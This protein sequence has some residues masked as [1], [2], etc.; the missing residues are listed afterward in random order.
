MQQA[1]RQQYFDEFFCGR[2][3]RPGETF[4]DSG[5][6]PSLTAKNILE[7]LEV[8]TSL[9]VKIPEF[10]ANLLF[11]WCLYGLVFYLETIGVS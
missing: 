9:F 10:K 6:F 1:K 3:N 5:D 4:L 11:F 7:R 2:R 8:Q